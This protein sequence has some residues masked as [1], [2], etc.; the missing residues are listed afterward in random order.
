MADDA[1]ALK[2]AVERR[3]TLAKAVKVDPS[4]VALKSPNKFEPSAPLDVS[5][6]GE[7]ND[8]SAPGGNGGG[9]DDD[10]DDDDDDDEDAGA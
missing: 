8:A 5:R 10:D 9:G 3:V 6:G 1:K 4:V 7:G 2:D